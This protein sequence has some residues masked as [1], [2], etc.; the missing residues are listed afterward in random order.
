[1]NTTTPLLR[2][3]LE[4]DENLLNEAMKLGNLKTKKQVIEN[5]LKEFVA[6]R[7]KK[8]LYDLFDAE[9]NLI[10]DDYDYKTMRGGVI[11]K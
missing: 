2:T 5:A 1:M 10:A 11:Q 3:S 6:K 9:E 7:K 4:I 8:N